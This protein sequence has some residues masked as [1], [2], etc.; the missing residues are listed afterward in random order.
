MKKR[1]NAPAEKKVPGFFLLNMLIEEIKE[2]LTATF[3]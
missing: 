2:G 3:Y 1:I